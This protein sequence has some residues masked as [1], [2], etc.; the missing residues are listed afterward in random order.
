[1]TT[2]AEEFQAIHADMVRRGLIP[3][4]RDLSQPD[5]P[6]RRL[7]V[8]PATPAVPEADAQPDLLSGTASAAPTARPTQGIAGMVR[9]D[10]PATSRQAAESLLP[11]LTALHQAVLRA[12]R[13]H[14]ALTDAELE[15]LEEFRGYSPST[16]RKRRSELTRDH[17]LLCETGG[18]RPNARGTAQL[19][20]WRLAPTAGAPNPEVLSDILPRV[21]D[22]L[23]A[24]R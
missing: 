1:M 6:R 12:F 8:V 3:P 23:E 15:T 16:I 5:P 22:A 7:R 19:T 24:D 2:P 20:V 11:H 18:T 13:H 17:R 14:G 21:T 9:H 10:S 4:P